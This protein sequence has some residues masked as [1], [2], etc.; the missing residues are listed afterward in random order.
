M[1]SLDH[2]QYSRILVRG[3]NWLGDAVMS[4]PALVRLKEA[5][6]QAAI[7][8]LTPAK[9]AELWENHPAIDALLAYQPN[10]SALTV[11]RRLRTNAFEAA[12][13][14]PNSFRSAWESWLARIPKRIGHAG[15]LR[16]W[17]LTTPLPQRPGY[18]RMVKRSRNEVLRV[19]EK[20]E[21]KGR[22]PQRKTYER[23][24][25]HVF[26]YLHLAAALGADDAPLAPQLFPRAKDIEQFQMRF[27]VRQRPGK[28]IF[29]LNPGAEFGPAKRWPVERF[30]AAGQQIQ[31]LTGCQWLIFGGKRDVDL[32]SRVATA[33]HA[34]KGISQTDVINLAGATSL[35]ELCAGVSLCRAFLTNDTGPMHV[36]AAVGVPVV[37][38]FGSTS[39]ELTGPGIPAVAPQ[40]WLKADVPCAPCFLRECPIDFRCMRSISVEVVVKEFLAAAQTNWKLTEN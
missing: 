22:M 1:R 35:R 23:A 4:I 5:Q 16:T 38:P 26:Q 33:L 20:A 14:L 21:A 32:G 25:H 13:I 28:P 30:I 3:V 9:I 12:L 7:T 31:Q 39:P 8:L 40:G 19:V 27:Q 17:L 11:A 34:G 6:P 29:G 15:Q 36:A 24:S 18:V 2:R 37:V 10:E